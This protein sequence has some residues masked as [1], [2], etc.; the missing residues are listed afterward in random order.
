MKDVDMILKNT[1]IAVSMS[2]F[3]ANAATAG[4]ADFTLTNRTGYDIESVYIAPSKQK[5]WGND[6]LGDNILANG[7]SRFIAFN[8]SGK[9]CIYDMS[10]SWVGYSSN[11]DVIWERLNLCEINK[12]TLRYNSKTNKTSITTD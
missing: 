4:D 5:D 2:L 6:H 9:N 12:I 10:I 7:K 8:K 1:L 3:L 11:D